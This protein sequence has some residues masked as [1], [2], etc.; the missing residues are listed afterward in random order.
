MTAVTIRCD[1][2][3]RFVEGEYGAWGVTKGYYWV[4]A[5]SPWQRYSQPGERYIC[6]CCMWKDAGYIRDFGPRAHDHECVPG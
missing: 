3:N 2:C 1:R 6:E 5:G 4:A